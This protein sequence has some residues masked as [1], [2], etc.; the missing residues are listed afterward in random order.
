M[1]HIVIR[2]IDW[3]SARAAIF[4]LALA[5]GVTA[6]WA[7]DGTAAAAKPLPVA[8]V[9]T[10]NTLS[11]GPHAGYRANHAK[12]VLARVCHHAQPT[13]MESTT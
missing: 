13:S 5:A 9:D 4:T 12:G 2:L 3:H 11:G 1:N 6:S 10:L 8:I 7:A